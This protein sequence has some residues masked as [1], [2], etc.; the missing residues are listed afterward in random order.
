MQQFRQHKLASKR[1]TLRAKINWLV[2]LNIVLVLTL[3]ISVICYM[4][5]NNEF[6]DIG[7]RAVALAK[8]VADMRQIKRGLEQ[9]NPA[10]AI[11]P[12]TENIKLVTGA[13]FIVVADMNLIR[14]SHPN[15]LLIGKNMGTDPGDDQ[16]VLKGETSISRATGSLGL[17]VRG[18][19]P[20][21]NSQHHQIGLVSVGFL[22]SDIWNKI[23]LFLLRTIGSGIVA[24]ALGLWGAY[25]LSGHI[26]KQTFNME[27]FEIAFLSQEQASILESIREGIIAV[28][29][30]GMITTCNQE[31][32]RLLGVESSD[33][34][35][36]FIETIIPNSRLPEVLEEGIS[37]NDQPM[38]ISNTLVIVNR[39]P[40][41]LKGHVIGAVA[42]FRDKIQLEQID[43]RLADVGK[44][45]DALRSQRHEFMNKLHTISGLIQLEEYELVRELIH[46]VNEEQQQVLTFFMSRIR[47]PAIVGTLI[48]K[49]HR[50]KE[51]GITLSID[52]KS[53]LADPCKHREIVITIL[54]NAI[55]NAIESITGS[56]NPLCRPEI[57]VF[58]NDETEHLIVNVE[59][60]GPG[61]D[62][63]LKERI[64]EDGMTTKGPGRGFG[65]ALLSKLVA[66]AGG[67]LSI[68][69][70]YE[71]AILE[72][73]LPN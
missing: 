9:S 3:V 21:F 36:Q 73:K 67:N 45:A 72:A 14:Y 51:Q 6:E 41:T 20:V 50:A 44:Y 56:Q 30:E 4:F 68:L 52:P 65:L 10:A 59:D 17:S 33:I 15:P 31:A 29:R 58:I 40:V 64:F 54:G 12:I 32:K 27:P 47:D 16:K 38:I 66:D 46:K 24:L 13:Q 37:H 11:Q 35:G 28:D 1:M 63:S 7:Q 25:L 8:T 61:I 39:V 62:P 18:K 71:G 48:G 60:K 19:A 70:S 23:S 57:N 43:Q 69:S 22:V 55:E 34:I 53:H 42:S 5:I 26:K 2:F 49:V